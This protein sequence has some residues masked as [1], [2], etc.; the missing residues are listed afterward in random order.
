MKNERGNI[1][2]AA[3]VKFYDE[4]ANEE[5][6]VSCMIPVNDFHEAV[7]KIEEYFG[8]D[9][10]I[11]IDF[12]HISPDDVMVFDSMESINLFNQLENYIKENVVW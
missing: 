5:T 6:C 10:L 8:A 3:R 4:F 7:T 12:E 9:N 1:M 11:K 2:F